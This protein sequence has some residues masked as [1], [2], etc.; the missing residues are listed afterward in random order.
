MS[1]VFSF[2]QVSEG[3]AGG[4]RTGCGPHLYFLLSLAHT[5]EPGKRGR[6]FSFQF[7]SARGAIVSVRRT[8]PYV[9]SCYRRVSQAHKRLSELDEPGAGQIAWVSQ[10]VGDRELLGGPADGACC[11]VLPGILELW[12]QLPAACS[13][14]GDRGVGLLELPYVGT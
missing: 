14:P 8:V 2:P 10:P 6:V 12:S 9:L 7:S 11:R 1:I 3:E 4:V 5:A 13:V